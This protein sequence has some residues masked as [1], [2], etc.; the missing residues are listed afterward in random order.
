MNQE[1]LWAAELEREMAA[2]P[3]VRRVVRERLQLLNFYMAK[4][5]TLRMAA[6][7]AAFPC[8]L[9]GSGDEPVTSRELTLPAPTIN[10]WE[11]RTMPTPLKIDHVY[12]PAT[13][14]SPAIGSHGQPLLA[15][16]IPQDLLGRFG[17]QNLLYPKLQR[18]AR[19]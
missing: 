6:L 2:N 19:A 3:E 18:R 4:T 8:L 15:G 11:P 5:P 9:V 12:Y 13:L 1:F 16:L 17:M 10:P 7:R 14:H